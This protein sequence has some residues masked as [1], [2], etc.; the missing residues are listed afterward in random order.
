MKKPVKIIMLC[1]MM[2][3]IPIVIIVLVMW[4]AGQDPDKT[5]WMKTIMMIWSAGLFIMAGIISFVYRKE[6]FHDIKTFV[7]ND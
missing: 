5:P 2:L 4:C 6:L 3:I 7:N 1:W